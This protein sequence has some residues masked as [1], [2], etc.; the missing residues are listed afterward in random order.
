MKRVLIVDDSRT[1]RLILRR[2]LTEI[3]LSVVEAG[4]GS[5]AL[6]VVDTEPAGL[7]LVMADW[8]MPE[9]NGFD[10]LTKLRERTEL[11]SLK[12]VMVT[13]EAELGHMT[14]AL[15]AGAN[16][17]IMKPFTKEIVKEKLELLGMLAAVGV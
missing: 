2:I 13:T 4:N 17:Y 15:E 3:G 14:M 6:V 1:I 16:E 9:M 7:D 10:L 12:V 11:S 5:E 8:N